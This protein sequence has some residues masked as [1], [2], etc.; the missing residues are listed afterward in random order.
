MGEK[1]GFELS[2]SQRFVQVI[3]DSAFADEDRFGARKIRSHSDD[4]TVAVSAIR[5]VERAESTRGSAR[6]RP[7][8]PSSVG[9]SASQN[10][11][12]PLAGPGIGA[13]RRTAVDDHFPDTGGVLLR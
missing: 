5:P 10:A 6:W 12:R 13:P 3:A 8:W 11:A 1:C 4:E 7:D 2:G 9:C